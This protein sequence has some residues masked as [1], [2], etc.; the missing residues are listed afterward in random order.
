MENLDIYANESKCKDKIFYGWFVKESKLKYMWTDENNEV[1][2]V[3]FVTEE[4]YLLNDVITYQVNDCE[5]LGAVY[6]CLGIIKNEDSK[7]QNNIRTM[8]DYDFED[9]S[10]NIHL[11]LDRDDDFDDYDE[12]H[13][14]NKRRSYYSDDD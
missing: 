3:S 11:C 4:Q 10:D 1:V 6:Y 7:E 9:A 8:D 5:F 2:L 12:Y 13:T 14:Q